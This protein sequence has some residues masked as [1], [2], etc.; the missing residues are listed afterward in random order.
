MRGF[1]EKKNLA[2][3]SAILY[4]KLAFKLDSPKQLH[5]KLMI[6]VLYVIVR[7]EAIVI[8]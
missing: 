8:I 1:H 7:E 2:P 4:L 6:T 5:P 3:K